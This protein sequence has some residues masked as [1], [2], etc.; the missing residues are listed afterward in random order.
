[1]RVEGHPK[2]SQT[3]VFII[4]PILLIYMPSLIMFKEF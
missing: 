1:M 3:E 4:F 2:K